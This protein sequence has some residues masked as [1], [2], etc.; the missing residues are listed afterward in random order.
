MLCGAAG[1]KAGPPAP[2]R[3]LGTAI[4][5]AGAGPNRP[6]AAGGGDRGWCWAQAEA[7][8]G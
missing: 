4:C 5:Q 3:T 8:S 2:S 7:Q 6:A 1:G